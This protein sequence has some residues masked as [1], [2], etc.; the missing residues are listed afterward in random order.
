MKKIYI[1]PSLEV[2]KIQTQSMIAG[3]TPKVIVDTDED[4]IDAGTVESRR[5]DMWDDEEEEDF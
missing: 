3:S 1:Q 5:R 4:A 2:T